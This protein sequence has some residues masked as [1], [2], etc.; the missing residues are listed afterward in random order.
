MFKIFRILGRFG[1]WFFLARNENMDYRFAGRFNL[2]GISN[3][4]SSNRQSS[5]ELVFRLLTQMAFQGTFQVI[6]ISRRL[7]FHDYREN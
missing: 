1:V 2:G 6:L 4:M 7:D 5:A 3:V